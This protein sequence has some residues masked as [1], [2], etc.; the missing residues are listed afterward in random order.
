MSRDHVRAIAIG[1][2]RPGGRA[3]YEHMGKLQAATSRE[4][5]AAISHPKTIV[6][7]YHGSPGNCK[8][9]RK[10]HPSVA[11]KNGHK[12]EIPH[13]AC[14]QPGCKKSGF[15]FRDW[16][17]RAKTFG[18]HPPMS[19]SRWSEGSAETFAPKDETQD[20]GPAY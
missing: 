4:T 9:I 15:S 16:H 2:N 1:G 13:Q 12:F 14:L 7:H 8:G 17:A 20:F 10:A 19:A 3:I 6:H 18:W 11:L 5:A